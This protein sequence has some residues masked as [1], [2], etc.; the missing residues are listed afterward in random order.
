[1]IVT[2]RLTLVLCVI[3]CE[4]KLQYKLIFID[5]YTGMYYIFTIV[6]NF[7]FLQMSKGDFSVV[8]FIGVSITSGENIFPSEKLRPRNLSPPVNSK[9]FVKVEIDVPEDIRD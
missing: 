9:T 8:E 5:N 7:P 6:Y 1:M 3:R 2:C 4:I